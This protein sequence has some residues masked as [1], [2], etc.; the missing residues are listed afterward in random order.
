VNLISLV[1]AA[2][3]ASVSLMGESAEGYIKIGSVRK[4]LRYASAARVPDRFDHSKQVLHLVLSDGPVPVNAVFD[5]LRLFSI[6]SRAGI[7]AVEFDF[8]EKVDDVHWFFSAVGEMGTMSMSQSPNPFPYKITG[9]VMKGKIEATS[10]P[11]GDRS[12]YEISVAYSAVIEKPVV[13]VPPTAADAAAAKDHP[14]AKAYLE[15]LDAVMKGDKARLLAAMPPEARAEIEAADF[16]QLLPALQQMQPKNLKILRA[17]EQDGVVTLWLSG[18]V[19]GKPQK[20][21]VE[22][23]LE[24]GHWFARE[25]IW[26][27][28]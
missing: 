17:R 12:G 8:S 27:G 15:R 7:Q 21:D 18:I 14:A 26:N 19:D 5:G 11:E 4:E 1:T 24:N 13:E 3:L 22:M 28:Q 2:L 10:K 20:G 9:D 6:T 16:K 25:E 23:Y